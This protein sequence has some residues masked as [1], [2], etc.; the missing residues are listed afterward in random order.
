MKS[1]AVLL[2]AI[3]LSLA[4]LVGLALA[5]TYVLSAALPQAELGSVLIAASILLIVAINGFLSMFRLFLASS[6]A[7]VDRQ[8]DSLPP[9]DEIHKET[10]EVVFA[11]TGHTGRRSPRRK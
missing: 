9:E 4:I 11:P 10:I 3:L 8:E 6:D 1:L 2:F 5:T 7:D